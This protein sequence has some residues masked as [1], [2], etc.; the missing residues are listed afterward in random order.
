MRSVRKLLI[1]CVALSVMTTWA[2]AYEEVEDLVD[3]YTT[4]SAFV[5]VVDGRRFFSES[6]RS[7]EKILWQEAKGEVGAFLT[8]T[9]LLAISVRSGQWNT[10]YLKITEKNKR[11]QMLIAAHLVIMLSSERIVS[12]GT[13][14]GGFIQTRLPIGEPVVA[15]ETEGRV[16][17]VVTPSR[18]FGF[19]SY[20]RGVS[21]IRFR[22]QETL[23]SLK[24]TYN[25]ITM[26]TS[27]RLIT[28]KAEDAVW[29]H[30]DLK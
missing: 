15:K 13:H 2:R 25:K 14:T 12:F 9:R 17:A 29:R 16:A 11:P 8:S 28:L 27:Q 23:V 26:R 10:H 3:I 20:R 30:V 5:A 24:T 21:E 22:L 6:Y 1:A 18:A 4:D 19:S 7:N